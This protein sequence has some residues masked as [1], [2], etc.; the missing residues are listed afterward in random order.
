MTPTLSGQE[1]AQKRCLAI[2]LA[3]GEGKRM[4]SAQPKALHRIGGRSMLAHVLDSVRRA[5]ADGIAVVVGPD[6]ADVAAEALRVRAGR[7]YLYPDRAARAPPMRCSRPATF[8]RGAMTTVLVVFA[9]TPLVRP[10]TFALLLGE[11][12]RRRGRRGAGVRARRP[13]RLWPAA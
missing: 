6:R 9:D 13:R 5:G 12:R 7:R 11:A 8:C 1:G 2:V 3:A 10:E 4:R